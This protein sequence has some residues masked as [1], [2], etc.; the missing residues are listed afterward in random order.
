YSELFDVPPPENDKQ[1]LQLS[2]KI[3][4]WIN[5]G[6]PEPGMVGKQISDEEEEKLE[7]EE[8]KQT[9]EETKPKKKRGMFGFFRK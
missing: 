2:R 8:E 5:K 1:A 9:K 3:K 6:K 4:E 7:S